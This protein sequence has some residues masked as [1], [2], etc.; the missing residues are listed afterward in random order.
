LLEDVVEDVKE[1]AICSSAIQ[2]SASEKP[3]AS[4]LSSGR[5]LGQGE[6]VG[7][8]AV[9]LPVKMPSELLP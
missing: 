3:L 7:E 1:D 8:P 2:T 9:E 5:L 4:V 6:Y